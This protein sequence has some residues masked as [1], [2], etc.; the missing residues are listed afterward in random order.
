MKSIIRQV[1]LILLSLAIATS[2]AKMYL[3]Y[4]GYCFDKNKYLSSQ[5]KINIAVEYVMSAYPPVIDVYEKSGSELDFLTRDKPKY[6]L[7]YESLDDFLSE[8]KDCCEIRNYGMK[9]YEVPFSY[10]IFGGLSGFVRVKYSV[11]Y[12]DSDVDFL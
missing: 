2:S 8:N 10:R 5:E 4:S 11:R 1:F 3:S 9:N 12:R 7:K 6:P